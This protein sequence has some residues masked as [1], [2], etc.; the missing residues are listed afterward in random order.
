MEK[1]DSVLC[2]WI[3]LYNYFNYF[4]IHF[5]F[6]YLHT[7][8]KPNKIKPSLAQKL[9]LTLKFSTIKIWTNVPLWTHMG[10]KGW[11]KDGKT[12][13]RCY[14]IALKSWD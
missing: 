9:K 11:R 10:H 13:I 1:L 7:F 2:E 14:A 3:V 8:Y 12:F 4:N 5:Q 6:S